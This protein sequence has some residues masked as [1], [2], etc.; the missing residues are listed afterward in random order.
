VKGT[1]AGTPI[2]RLVA[3][4]R[5]SRGRRAFEN[6]RR[7]QLLLARTARPLA[8]LEERGPAG[9][10]GASVLVLEKVGEAELDVYR[11]ESEVAAH[12]LADCVAEGIAELHAVG[13]LHGDLKGSNVRI[14]RRHEVAAT[15]ASRA[16][17]DFW[18]V[19]LED[20][21]WRTRPSDDARLEA[22]SQL[23]A[24]LPDAHFACAVREAALARA[25]ALLPFDAAHLDF[26]GAR[27]EIVRR[28]LA[29]NHRWRGDG[30]R[31]AAQ[32]TFTVSQRK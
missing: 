2:G 9:S 19:D 24:S 20:L 26:A 17:F 28:S 18:L 14:G 3:G 1:A 25:L 23:N 5:G 6:G 11:P 15:D 4:V 22:W 32:P 27:R 8:W 13:V 31:D 16:G 12:A 29:R 21:A 7:E 30:A 10:R